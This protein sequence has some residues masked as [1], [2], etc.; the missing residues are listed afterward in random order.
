NGVPP[1]LLGGG[2]KTWLAAM[3]FAKSFCDTAIEEHSHVQTMFGY[4]AAKLNKN[5][6]M[7]LGAG[8][9][10]AYLVGDLRAC[11]NAACDKLENAPEY[12]ELQRVFLKWIPKVSVLKK[13]LFTLML[14]LYCAKTFVLDS[15]SALS[16]ESQ[17]RS[18]TGKRNAIFESNVGGLFDEVIFKNLGP[19]LAYYTLT[20]HNVIGRD[21][22]GNS[23]YKKRYKDDKEALLANNHAWKRSVLIATRR[24]TDVLE[25]VLTD[26][27]ISG[28]GIKGL[29]KLRGSSAGLIDP[30][31]PSFV[32]DWLFTTGV[33]A[34]CDADENKEKSSWISE[35]VREHAVALNRDD[36]SVLCNM[37]VLGSNRISGKNP[38]KAGQI[39]GM[40]A[41]KYGV[42]KMST[43]GLEKILGGVAPTVT[44]R[45]DSAIF[46]LGKFAAKLGIISKK[47]LQKKAKSARKKRNEIR[48]ALHACSKLFNVYSSQVA[49]MSKQMVMGVR[50]LLAKILGDPM[51]LY[52]SFDAESTN[53]IFARSCS[54]WILETSKIFEN[55]EERNK[56]WKEKLLSWGTLGRTVHVLA[57]GT[58][59][60]LFNSESED[61]EAQPVT[62][63]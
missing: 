29:N 22:D 5:E 51:L 34:L 54:K 26:K 37:Q 21:E 28:F 48:N 10:A 27:F 63:S 42:E 19:A 46:A 52:S 31:L 23:N 62:F 33:A 56:P 38:Q 55:K 25:S 8:S 6:I 49:M 30:E 14:S 59:W 40:M 20:K 11:I 12:K 44:R 2:Q 1:K 39:A 4:G 17:M 15:A 3:H 50:T 41:L 13:T 16:V 58:L 18:V 61:K 45:V 43:Y 57:M 47:K 36:T 24:L 35:K 32:H 53:R 60:Y 9:V 7:G